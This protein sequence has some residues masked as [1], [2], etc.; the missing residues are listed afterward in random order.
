MYMFKMF[1]WTVT[2]RRE[3]KPH[4][5]NTQAYGE[6]LASVKETTTASLRRTYR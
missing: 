4:P 2:I 1:G 3:R 6:K 5:M